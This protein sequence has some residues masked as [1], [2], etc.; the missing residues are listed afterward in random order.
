MDC[1][2]LNKQLYEAYTKGAIDNIKVDSFCTT[3]QKLRESILAVIHKSS[4]SYPHHPREQGM[5]RNHEIIKNACA[6][7]EAMDEPFRNEPYYSI[8]TR[9]L[10]QKD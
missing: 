8:Q 1:I 4:N 7:D 2:T 5:T 10:N 3:N 9:S 6:G